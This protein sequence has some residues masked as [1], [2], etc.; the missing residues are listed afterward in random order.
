MR[1]VAVL[2]PLVSL[3]SI[4]CA[5][6]EPAPQ[7]PSAEL[8]AEVMNPVD[9]TPSADGSD[10]F[11]VTDS[12]AASQLLVLDSGEVTTL[13]EF[14][15][16]RA[17]VAD[18]TR[19]VYVADTGVDA[20][21]SYDRGDANLQMISGTDGYGV[22]ALH[23]ADALYFV[24]S[25]NPGPALYSIAPE[26]GTVSSIASGFPGFVDGVTRADDGTLYATGEAVAGG[27]AANGALFEI[28]DGEPVVLA[29]GIHLGT[30]AGVAITPDEAT[31]MV[32]SLSDAGTSQV[33]LVSRIDGSTAAF[34]DVIREN[35]SS[36]GLHRAVDEP[37][38]FAWV[39]APM[40]PGG[41]H[42]VTF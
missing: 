3:L 27:G 6:P 9:A 25:I 18:S 32:S 2:P 21:F 42:R 24:G 5:E 16:A 35:T 19:F 11:I 4:A 31:V 15:H 30:P 20:V 34:D 39:D 12:D 28:V 8:V 22:R 29:D 23:I 40:G 36:G 7:G 41:I 37:T 33:L 38:V 13:A 10:I 26:G 14:E 17:V 1:V